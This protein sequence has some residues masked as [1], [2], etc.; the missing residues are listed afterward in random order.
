MRKVNWQPHDGPQLRVLS[1]PE[2]E[3]L[4]GGSRGGGKTDAGMAW[5]ASKP[6]KIERNDNGD[7]IGIGAHQ[8]KKF[9]GLVIRR[10]AD[11][12]SDWIARARD[13]YVDLNAK[14]VGNPPVIKFPSGAFIKTGHLKDENAYTKYQ[15]HEYQRILIEELTQIPREED[16]LKLIS[17]CRSTVPELR[18]QIF[19]TCNPGGPGHVWV[20]QRWVD[21]A[22]NK[23]YPDPISGRTRVFIPAKIGDNPTL[24]QNDPDYVHYL[25]SLPDDLRKAWRDGDWDIFAGQ[26]F[27]KLR[28]QLH[29]VEPFSIPSTWARFRSLDWGYGH[30]TVCLWW[31]VDHDKPSNVVIYRAYVR[32][33]TVVSDMAKNILSMTPPEEKIITT[34]ADPAVWVRNP[35]SEAKTDQTMA[36]VIRFAGLHIEKAN[37]DRINGWQAVRELLEWNTGKK[38]PRLRIFSTCK[39]VFHGLSILTHDEKKPE[40]VLKM[41]GDDIGDAVRYGAMH[42]YQLQ[43][44]E[45]E[46]NEQEKFIRKITDETRLPVMA[47]YSYTDD[48]D[49]L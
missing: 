29:L 33:E 44:P 22:R 13:F 1:R 42:L 25:D 46:L 2:F 12:L 34:T 23:T 49:N 48:W 5:I 36:D 35:Y 43:K 11:D 4:Y 41:D 21:T 47:D 15:G 39:E 38:L 32:S 20:K 27:K 3:I 37:N 8:H 9:R 16:Y 24:M 26:Y 19:A 7:D 18:P 45:R 17:S 30:N 14:F 10:N 28:E 40:D 6:W 31:A